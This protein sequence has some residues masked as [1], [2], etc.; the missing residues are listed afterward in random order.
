MRVRVIRLNYNIPPVHRTRAMEWETELKKKPFTTIYMFV[1]GAPL[2]RRA[3]YTPYAHLSSSPAFPTT[4]A[5]IERR[6]KTR[7]RKSVKIKK[8]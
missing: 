3:F 2:L 6:Y 7:R 1:Y 8:N 4:A 5:R